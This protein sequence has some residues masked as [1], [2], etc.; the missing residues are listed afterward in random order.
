MQVQKIDS[1]STF[2]NTVQ[3]KPKKDL[4]DRSMCNVS[5]FTLSSALV[6][7]FVSTKVTDLIVKKYSPKT[8]RMGL[9]GLVGIGILGLGFVSG[10]LFSIYDKNHPTKLGDFAYRIFHLNEGNEVDIQK[11]QTIQK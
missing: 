8:H 9:D 3:P 11:Q 1:N 4:W 7:M 6:D 5:L 2:G 10:K